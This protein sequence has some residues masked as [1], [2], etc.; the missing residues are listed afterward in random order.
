MNHDGEYSSDELDRKVTKC[1]Y[2]WTNNSSVLEFVFEKDPNLFLRKNKIVIRGAIKCD[3]NYIIENGFAA[4]LFSMATIEI[5]SQPITKN[6]NR[7][8]KHY[9]SRYKQLFRGEFFLTDRIYKIGNFD[10]KMIESAYNAEGHFDQY[11]FTKDELERFHDTDAIYKRTSGAHFEAY[12]N[13]N[14]GAG[15]YRYEFALT[16]NYG[17]LANPEPLLNNCQLKISFDRS[18]WATAISE[19]GVVSNKCTF[20]EI[21]DCHAVAEYVSSPRIRNY[22]EAIDMGPILY[23]YEDCD[24][25]VKSIPKNET[26]IR[27]DGLRGGNVPK[28]IFAAIIPQKNLNGN[29]EA[30]STRFENHGVEEFNIMLNGNSVNGYPIQLKHECPVYP[31]HKFL[32]VTGRLYNNECGSSFEFNTF[33]QNWIWSH[34][35]ELETSANGWVGISFKLKSGF[36]V[37]M[38][39]IVW[40]ISETT[41]GID[42]FHQIEKIN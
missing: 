5:E 35:F 3:K 16:P 11:N 8:Y 38:N 6:N 22:F 39:L 14:S 30:S 32:D 1:H 26:E 25:L 31:F 34:H 24:V 15:T 7:Y 40:L 21:E 4:K 13:D 37:P 36:T 27:F 29:P 2:P 12:P 9:R 18:N 17:F 33:K 42:K 20:L 10:S 41:L 19:R 28:Y 23:H